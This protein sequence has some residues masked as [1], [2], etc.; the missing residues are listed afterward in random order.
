MSHVICNPI[1][2]PYRYQA[3]HDGKG[4][5]A[6]FREAADPTLIRFKSHY[7]LFVSMSGGF[8]YSQDLVD[9]Q[10][11]ETPELPNYDYAPDVHEVNGR[12]IFSASRGDR[13]CTFYGSYDPINEPFEPI[14]APFIFW[15]PALFADDDGRLYFYWGCGNEHPLWGIEMDANFNPIGEKIAVM[16]ARHDIHGW[17]RHGEN[18][19]NPNAH[20]Y[21]EGA[22]VNK[23][24][25]KY[26]L[27][28]AAPGTEFNV[29]A[30]GVYVADAPL[31]P[32]TYQAHNPFSS[33]PGGFATGAGHG[34][35]FQDIAGNWWHIATIRI[36]V[37][38]I[39]ERRLGLFP[40]D[41]DAD[42]VKFCNQ[43]FADYPY[44]LPD[45]KRADMH[46]TAPMWNLLSYNKPTTAS[47]HQPNHASTLATNEDMTTWW[48][49]EET[50]TTP[51]LQLDLGAACTVHAIQVNFADHQ[52]TLPQQW[53]THPDAQ[54]HGRVI[55]TDRGGVSF[56]L[57]GSTD[58]QQ[59]HPLKDTRATPEDNP[60]DLIVPDTPQRYRYV[61]ISHISQTV[62]GAVSLSGLRVFGMGNGNAPASVDAF[63]ATRST[64]G[65]DA[66]ITWQAANGADG[67]NLRYGTTPN[68]LY[69]S[70]QVFGAN[71]LKFTFLTQGQP[72]YM[73]IDSFN[74]NG[75][76]AGTVHKID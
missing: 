4:G 19:S 10:F 11:K 24:N 37:N 69:S 30:N 8:W 50:D 21:I 28:Y 14:A 70:R 38:E 31:G 52:T 51:W 53:Q 22:F 56:L 73:A 42:G 65:M 5:A 16:R 1:S 74:E 27:Q 9:W 45:G 36:S 13:P 2:L 62:Q 39:F 3:K 29:Y 75:V 54:T 25:G 57:E 61:R 41:F 49:A 20:P 60:H 32:F 46:S 7:L 48:A 59:W 76:T 43:H 35:T 15:D 6:M 55:Y 71:S 63:T 72:C 68:K 26:Y 23:V 64:C 34:S 58:G 40:C 44:L 47:S 18:N 33:R 12:V 66:N 17:E 67:Y